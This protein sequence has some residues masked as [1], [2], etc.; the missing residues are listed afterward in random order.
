M[1]DV[2]LIIEGAFDAAARA[3]ENRSLEVAFRIRIES[4]NKLAIV[5]GID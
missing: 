4:L 5:S 1:I 2:E 3:L